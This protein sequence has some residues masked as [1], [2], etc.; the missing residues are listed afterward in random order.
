[1]ML[2]MQETQQKVGPFTLDM[3]LCLFHT[4]GGGRVTIRT[5]VYF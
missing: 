1:M 5:S 3:E 2:A 4:Q